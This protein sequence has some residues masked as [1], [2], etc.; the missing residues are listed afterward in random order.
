M[1]IFW[2][3]SFL[4][5]CFELIEMGQLFL[6]HHVCLVQARRIIYMM[7]LKGQFRDL[8]LCQSHGLNQV[9]HVAYQSMRVDE[10]NTS[11]PFANLYL[12]SIE[13]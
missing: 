9:D 3:K 8:T 10:V 7:I 4:E 2:V 11:V 12:Y 6:H 5:I 13:S 1:N